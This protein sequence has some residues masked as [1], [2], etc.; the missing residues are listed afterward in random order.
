M[1]PSHLNLKF[2]LLFELNGKNISFKTFR[3]L[4]AKYNMNITPNSIQK[5]SNLSLY[6]INHFNTRVCEQN[7]N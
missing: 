6:L 4:I 3:L 2:K 1:M 5:Q 7:L